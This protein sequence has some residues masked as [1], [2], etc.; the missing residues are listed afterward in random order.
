MA[1]FIYKVQL[2]DGS[3]ADVEAGPGMEAQAQAAAVAAW[4]KSRRLDTSATVM[5]TGQATANNNPISQTGLAARYIAKAG[6]S[7]PAML[8]DAVTGPLN[9]AQDKILG[10]GRGYR[11]QAQMPAVDRALTGL[12]LPAPDT[13]FQRKVGMATEL[14]TAGGFGAKL[15]DMASRSARSVFDNVLNPSTYQG[16]LQQRTQALPGALER[17]ARDPG[18]QVVAG[19]SGGYMGQEA[20]ERG[21]NGGAQFLAALGGSLAGAGA[22]G[23]ARSAT[24]AAQRAMTPVAQIGDIERRIVIAL[25]EQGIDPATIN[26]A[27][28]RSLVEDAQRALQLNG[29]GQLDANALARLADY[30]RLNLT[31]TKAAIT[32]DPFDV[33]AQQNSLKQS[34]NLGPG[35]GRLPTIADTNNKALVERMQGFNPSNDA[36]GLGSAAMQ[37]ILQRDAA[38]QQAKREA[39]NAANA[40]AGGDIPLQKGGLNGIWEELQ[41][42]RKIRFLPEQ[43]AGT[44]NDI[45]GDTRAPFTVNNLDELL[46]TIS[47]AQRGTQDGNVKAAL[48]IA[49]DYLDNMPIRPDKAGLGGQTV[50]GPMGAAMAQADEAPRQLL[51][52]LNKARAANRSWREWQRSDPLIQRVVEG[53]QID[54]TFIDAI[55]AKG[56]SWRSVQRL[57]ELAGDTSS[58]EAIRSGIAQ[59]IKLAAFNGADDPSM[60]NFNGRAMLKTIDRIGERKLEQFFDADELATLRSMGRAGNAEVFQPRGSAVGNSNTAAAASRIVARYLDMLPAGREL[61][62][63][64]ARRLSVNWTERGL[65]PHQRALVSNVDPITPA[66]LLE[67]MAMPSIMGGGLLSVD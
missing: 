1:T 43:V 35:T 5:P 29:G 17:A 37:A 8:A 25:Q 11:F 61:A 31:P 9:Y 50:T 52:A 66:G 19:A 15:A 34:A 48:G 55:M 44:I 40:M 58:R 54:D 42:Q 10:E 23:A 30:R 3:V 60:V 62:T 32:L 56:T 38:M 63:D 51:D 36:A 2:P 39:Y 59:R 7:L 49:R 16:F 14:G 53:N 47:T 46:T 13:E 67:L 57:A 64:P 20:Q 24:N 28:R 21:M 4:Q 26:P 18:A 33:T 22:L 45:L 12:G 27:M 6:A 41:R 65:I